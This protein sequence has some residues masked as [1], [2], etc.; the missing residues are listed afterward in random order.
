GLLELGA[1]RLKVVPFPTHR[2]G[3]DARAP[4]NLPMSAVCVLYLKI[5]AKKPLT[6]PRTPFRGSV[7][8]G[9]SA[10]V[11]SGA[12][13][14]TC[15]RDRICDESSGSATAGGKSLARK[16]NGASTST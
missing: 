4:S 12:G 9:G 2:Y 3:W 11:R 1:A 7:L 10:I 14:E 5:E 8:G 6:L 15:D 16:T 13:E